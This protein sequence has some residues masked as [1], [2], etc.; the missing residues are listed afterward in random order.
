MTYQSRNLVYSQCVVI[1][2]ILGYNIELNHAVFFT[3]GDYIDR[4]ILNLN[5]QNVGKIDCF[6]AF[7]SIKINVGIG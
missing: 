3:V 6:P 2:R 1:N 5:K 4:T 7:N